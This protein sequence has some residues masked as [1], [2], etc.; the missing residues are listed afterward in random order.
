MT[1]E[2][3]IVAATHGT[4]KV[5]LDS[6]SETAFANHLKSYLAPDEIKILYSRYASGF[7]KYD[8]MMR[9]VIWKALA[10]KVGNGLKIGIGVKFEHLETITFGD[11]VF[12]GDSSHIQGRYDGEAFFDSGCWIGPQSFIDARCLKISSKVGLGPG[13][14]I[15]GSVH[16]GFPIEKAI[17]ETDLEVNPITIDEDADIGTGAIILP[18]VTIGKGAIV[19]AGAV[20]NKCVKA[21][22]VVAGVPAKQISTRDS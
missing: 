5:I 22:E 11:N 7:D 12:V 13:I 15:L 3:R 19:G 10:K 6:P 2:K 14:K 20:V 16:T 9:R 21:Y 18:G 17:I 1:L 4:K 8:F